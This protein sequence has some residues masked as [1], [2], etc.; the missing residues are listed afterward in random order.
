MGLA[1]MSVVRHSIVIDD[2]LRCFEDRRIR[3]GAFGVVLGRAGLLWNCKGWGGPAYGIPGLSQ[4]V[5]VSRLRFLFARIMSFDAC[6]IRVCRVM[7]W[8]CIGWKG[9]GENARWKFGETCCLLAPLLEMRV[10]A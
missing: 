4:A 6:E 2:A 8:W 7:R 9:K 1:R 10:L 5:R 3:W